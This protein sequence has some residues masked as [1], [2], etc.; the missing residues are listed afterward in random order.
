MLSVLT[1]LSALPNFRIPD[2]IELAKKWEMHA[3][4]ES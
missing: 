3:E 2:D 4:R 1:Q